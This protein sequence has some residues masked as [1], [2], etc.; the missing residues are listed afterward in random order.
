M[1][2]KSR[3]ALRYPSPALLEGAKRPDAVW[4]GG[5]TPVARYDR[6]ATFLS[7][8]RKGG[9]FPPAGGVERGFQNVLRRADD[10]RRRSDDQR[11]GADDDA[12]VLVRV[13][14]RGEEVLHAVD[15]RALLVVGLDDR[16]GRVGGVG[17]EEHRLLRLGV[18]VPLVE[19]RLVDRRQLP[20]LERIG[21]ARGEAASLRL[22]GDREPVF[23][24]ADAGAHQHP[25]DLGA[26]AHEFE[27]FVGLAEAHDALDAG[28]IVPGAIEEH[29][30]AGGG[31]MPDVALEIPLRAL[32]L[33]RLLQR[34]DAR[35]ARVEMLHEA[36]DGAALAGG[37]TPL[38]QNHDLFA[39]FLD[40]VLRFQELRLQGQHALHVMGFADLG[41]VGIVAGLEGAADRVGIV[42]QRLDFDPVGLPL[43]RFLDFL[44]TPARGEGRRDDDGDGR[45]RRR[46][47]G[48]V[49]L[50]RRFDLALDAHA[51]APVSLRAPGRE[52]ARSSLFTSRGVA[53]Q[54]AVAWT[55]AGERLRSCPARL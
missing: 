25:L 7:R 24:Q 8:A 50:Q 36:L 20:L 13:R 19:R 6:P 16:P 39:G 5:S 35:A 10:Q 40:P 22:A 52:R 2:P 27:I 26:L 42:A 3:P 15:A 23:E 55:D 33:V 17:V 1:N 9:S 45:V 37:V 14:Q 29:D 51:A 48:T 21:L 41:L 47:L 43:L 32:A 53:S 11:V 34:H 12:P 18:V 49:G 54:D 30:L 38:E 44:Y 46:A 31:Q 28:A 4:P